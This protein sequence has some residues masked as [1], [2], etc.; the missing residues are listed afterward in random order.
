MEYEK[1]VPDVDDYDDDN[2]L[3]SLFC[4]FCAA[5]GRARPS[6]R[7]AGGTESCEKRRKKLRKTAAKFEL[8]LERTSPA[9]LTFRNKDCF[10]FAGL[11]GRPLAAASG[12]S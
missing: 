8:C 11:A 10:C 12:V 1:L 9:L 7:Q 3:A 2:S 4:L 5:L 6:P